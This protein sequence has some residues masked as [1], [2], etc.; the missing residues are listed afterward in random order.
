MGRSL[1]GFCGI[2]VL[3][4]AVLAAGCGGAK[5]G[6]EQSVAAPKDSDKSSQS[7]TTPKE[8]DKSVNATTISLPAGYPTDVMPLFPGAKLIEVNQLGKSQILTLVTEKSVQEVYDYYSNQAKATKKYELKEDSKQTGKLAVFR[9]NGSKGGY[10]YEV[11]G[12]SMKT[13]GKDSTQII[14][15]MTKEK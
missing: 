13:N 3:C 5:S 15:G 14:I 10:F 12:D 2:V 8:N 1:L 4:L 7:A 11:G 9:L 6:S